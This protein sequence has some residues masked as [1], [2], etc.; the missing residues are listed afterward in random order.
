MLI[1]SP[2]HRRAD[3]ELWRSLEEADQVAG[4]SR[5]SAARIGES[6]RSIAVFAGEGT[7]YAGI[8]WGKDS[9]V[10]AYLLWLEAP[11]IPL[12]HLRPTNHN[13]D[14]DAVRDDYLARFCGQ[15]YREVP[16]DYG[17]LHSRRL[18]DC[19][20]DRKTDE[21][22]YRAIG[23]SEKRHGGRRILGIRSA[24][25]FGRMIR[26]LRWGLTTANTLR[27]S[28]DGA[29]PRSL[30]FWPSTDCPFIRP[31]RCW[32][33]VAG[34]EKGSGSPRSATPTEREAGVG[35]GKRSIMATS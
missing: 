9:V 15:P 1:G 12:I 23:D 2:R 16:V 4:R 29:A 13:P 32:A 26:T 34:P 21:Q 28:P 11:G 35:S 10:L 5:P 30:A 33:R 3:L 8:S 19:Q 17:D 24:E 6:R 27:R 14:C 31:M 18:A 25:S 22:W 20:L 7:C